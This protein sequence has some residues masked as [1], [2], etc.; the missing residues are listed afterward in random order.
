MTS[1]IRHLLLEGT[2]RERGLC[3]GKAF[4]DEIKTCVEKRMKLLATYGVEPGQRHSMEDIL[5][6]ARVCWDEH[7]AFC[8]ELME[9][10]E[11]IAAGCGAD[12]L[13]LFIMNGYT[14]FRD[15]VRSHASPEEGCTNATV[16][17][18]QTV[19]GHGLFCQ[20]WDMNASA[21]EH[22]VV[23]EVR[24]DNGPSVMLLSLTGCVGMV[25]MNRHGVCAG[26]DNLT[27]QEG[28]PGLF[29]VFIIRKM[30]EMSTVEEA[31][32]VL[33]SAEVAGGHNYV[34]TGPDGRGYN[35]E[36]LPQRRHITETG[37][38]S[39]HTNH[40]FNPEMAALECFPSASTEIASRARHAG[41]RKFLERNLGKFDMEKM[42]E[43][44]R[45]EAGEGSV[46]RRTEEEH[47]ICTCGAAIAVPALGEFWM[48][49]GI[50]ADNEYQCFKLG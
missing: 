12:P 45:L 18:N 35:I 24:P 33:K 25:G 1:S 29:W 39:L 31:L 9:E 20:T 22:V 5:R 7:M 32:E 8:P 17:A 28:K 36:M 13:E 11:G 16:A 42:I 23:L 26:A 47:G 49:R 21:T 44:T 14:D 34:I 37:D 48:V 30:L 43:L 50:P 15:L 6:L 4:A 10:L 19:N 40:C 38:F 41:A 27:A 3:H 46:S 2:P